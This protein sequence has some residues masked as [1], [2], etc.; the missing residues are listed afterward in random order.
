MRVEGIG[1][2]L[3]SL[4]REVLG[5]DKVVLKPVIDMN[6]RVSVDAHEIPA[7]IRER[8]LLRDLYCVFPWCTRRATRSMDLDHVVPYDDGGPPGQTITANLAPCCRYHHRLKT[9]GGWNYVVLTEGT[10]E[11]ISPHGARFLVDHT[12][13][14]AIEDAAADSRL[15]PELDVT[16]GGAGVHVAGGS[17]QSTAPGR[18]R[19]RNTGRESRPRSRGAVGADQKRHWSGMLRAEDTR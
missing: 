1:P 13:S 15:S 7:R 4:L 17:V 2:V 14:W 8:V 11:W 3:A 6:E 12:G 5:H 9:H 19:K 18:R 16:A 10:Y